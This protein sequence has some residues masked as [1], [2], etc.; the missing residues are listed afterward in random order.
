MDENGAVLADSHN[1]KNIKNVSL[2]EIHTPELSVPGPRTPGAE[3]AV[4]KLRKYISR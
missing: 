2:I 4:A 1:I 3:I